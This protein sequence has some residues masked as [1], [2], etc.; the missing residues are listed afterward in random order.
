MPSHEP[1]QRTIVPYCSQCGT[2]RVMYGDKC[3]PCHL[4]VHNPEPFRLPDLDS[5]EVGDVYN[6]LTC[7]EAGLGK[8]RIEAHDFAGSIESPFQ[9]GATFLNTQEIDQ[10]IEWLQ[11]VKRRATLTGE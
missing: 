2:R 8:V 11:T 7:D 5:F 9:S 10:L 6:G 1:Q 3:R 4:Q